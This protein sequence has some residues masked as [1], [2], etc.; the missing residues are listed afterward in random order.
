MLPLAFFN[1]YANWGVNHSDA[2]HLVFILLLFQSTNGSEIFFTKLKFLFK[3]KLAVN[4]DNSGE[5]MWRSNIGKL[6]I[7]RVLPLRFCAGF[8]PISMVTTNAYLDVEK[9]TKRQ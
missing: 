1:F 6:P 8:V 2:I 5:P 7:F 9:M 4:K 3:F